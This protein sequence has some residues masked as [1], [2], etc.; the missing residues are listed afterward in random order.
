MQTPEGE[1]NGFSRLRL[2]CTDRF[3]GPVQLISHTLLLSFFLPFF[4]FFFLLVWCRRVGDVGRG[5]HP[6]QL[7]LWPESHIISTH[8]RDHDM[9]DVRRPLTPG[10]SAP[11]AS[12]SPPSARLC[13][14]GS[15][16]R[17]LHLSMK[18]RTSLKQRKRAM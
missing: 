7:T 2:P 13:F 14:Q 12:T 4:L 6:P 16:A 1:F 8:L 10:G 18:N 9:A 17:P 11:E 15:P 5:R 3:S